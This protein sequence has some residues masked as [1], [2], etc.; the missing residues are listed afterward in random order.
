MT[1]VFKFLLAL[2]AVG[3][4]VLMVL[5]LVYKHDQPW[6]YGALGELL[7]VNVLAIEGL[8]AISEL[9]HNQ[10]SARVSANAAVLSL[11][12]TYMSVDYHEK[13]RRPAWFCLLKARQD[14]NYRNV[15]LAQLCGASALELEHHEIDSADEVDD[16][17][18]K[19]WKFSNEYHRVHDVLA[20]FTTLSLLKADADVIR[21]CNFY[22]DSWRPPLHRIVLDLE[23]YV[24]VNASGRVAP[25]LEVERRR[26]KQ[27]RQTLTTLDKLFG[28]ELVDLNSDPLFQNADG[29][30]TESPLKRL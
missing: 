27:F 20:F 24:E 25:R 14:A 21:S 19:Y 17:Y 7:L 3:S 18:K 5:C 16:V 29:D 22:Y 11:H 30:R 1:G 15:L 2:A 8:V 28:L 13:V 4:A 12:Q 10:R 26:C 23:E 6:D 9:T